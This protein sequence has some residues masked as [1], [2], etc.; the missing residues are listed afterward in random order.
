MKA[1]INAHIYNTETAKVVCDVSYGWNGS[2]LDWHE[3]TLFRTKNETFFLAGKGC[4]SSM[5]AQR[6]G[7]L[8]TKGSGLRV[9]DANEARAQMEAAGCM[10][11]VYEAFGLALQEG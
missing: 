2:D 5:W 9:I 4:P 7:T 1:I 8:S 10:Q 3:T 6:H 11:H